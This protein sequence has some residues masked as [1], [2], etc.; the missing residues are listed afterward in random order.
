MKVNYDRAKIREGVQD[1]AYDERGLF[2]CVEHKG[3]HRYPSKK[4]LIDFLEGFKGVRG[5]ADVWSTDDLTN[6]TVT[7]HCEIVY[8]PGIL[9]G[10]KAR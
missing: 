4:M 9:R 5:T 1:G 2:K 7:I 10:E 3:R 8:K 6:G